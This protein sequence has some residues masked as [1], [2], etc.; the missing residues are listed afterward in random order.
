MAA[1]DVLFVSD[2]LYSSEAPRNKIWTNNI[3]SLRVE[4]LNDYFAHSISW[5]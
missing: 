3:R 1:F 2:S 5:N 4:L